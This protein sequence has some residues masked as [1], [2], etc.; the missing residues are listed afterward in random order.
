MSDGRMGN[1]AGG[2]RIGL[3]LGSTAAKGVLVAPDGT[4]AER[5]IDLSRGEPAGTS[6][7]LAWELS[8]RNGVK[9][10][11]VVATGYGRALAGT[12][13]R[14]V[15][16]ISCHA[17]GLH[18]QH[19]DAR[20]V[21]DI[22]GQDAKA[23]RLGPDGSVEDF[24][25]NDR[26]AA[27]T[28]SF[29]EMAARRFSLDVGELSAFCGD[30]AAEEPGEPRIEISSTCVVFAESE[31]VGL[32]AR[33]ADSKAVLRAVH[34]SIAKRVL[35]LLRQVKAPE[36]LYF[37]GGVAANLALADAIARESGLKVA[38]A[39]HPQFTG[40]LGAALF[41]RHPPVTLAI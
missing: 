5:I 18:A 31:L 26:C 8:A 19:P 27:G 37:T 34:R 20:S 32:A 11:L 21:L 25:M 7:R 6:E 33:G 29:L 1:A 17:R 30:S 22:G 36:P 39:D 13:A 9:D 4:V 40:A 38:V 15:T 2:W 3:D 24:S 14:T 41:A 12:A 10:A 28:G 23:I 35:F 16:E